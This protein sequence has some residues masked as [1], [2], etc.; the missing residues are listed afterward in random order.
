MYFL[1][2]HNVLFVQYIFL[3]TE[4]PQTYLKICVW[5]SHLTY[6]CP[7]LFECEEHDFFLHF[8]DFQT[9][10]PWFPP[11]YVP[12]ALECRAKYTFVSYTLMLQGYF[13]YRA[14]VLNKQHIVHCTNIN[15][16][17]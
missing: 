10:N 17:R 14:I 4:Q 16:E 3:T 6:I 9:L 1:T 5:V 13:G 15:L 11:K 7:I 8:C 2:L 12:V